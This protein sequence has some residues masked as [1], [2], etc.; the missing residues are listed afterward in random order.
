MQI[1]LYTTN[2]AVQFEISVE[3]SKESI[4]KALSEDSCIFQTV[5]GSYI[6]VNP[7]KAIAIEVRDLSE[8]ILSNENIDTPPVSQK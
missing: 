3:H 5:D 8:I 2:G 4:I 6:T 1:I 7:S